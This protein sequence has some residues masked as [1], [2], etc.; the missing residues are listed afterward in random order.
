MYYDGTGATRT[1]SQQTFTGDNPTGLNVSNYMRVAFTVAGTGSV[2]NG[3]FSKTEDVR[4]LNGQ[5]V[6]LSF[7]GKA[8]TTRNMNWQTYQEFGTG[9]S[10]AV[11]ANSQGF[12]FLRLGNAFP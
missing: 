9:G 3:I 6:T 7:Y 8:D 12:T 4:K 5:T 10:S 11:L 1:I 2:T